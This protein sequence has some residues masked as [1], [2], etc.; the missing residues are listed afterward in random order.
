MVEVCMANLMLPLLEAHYR[1][2][3]MDAAACPAFM[4]YS[5]QYT[6]RGGPP[7]RR[8]KPMRAAGPFPASRDSSA[9]RVKS[10]AIPLFPLTH[11]T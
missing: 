7:R 11:R 3:D 9:F 10:C 1:F 2:P 5:G 6:E 8:G 4:K